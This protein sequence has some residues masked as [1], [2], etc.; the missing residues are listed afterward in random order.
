MQDHSDLRER[1]EFHFLQV[2]AYSNLHGLGSES[3]FFGTTIHG[4]QI[5]R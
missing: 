3:V 4:I 1:I 5:V 2:T